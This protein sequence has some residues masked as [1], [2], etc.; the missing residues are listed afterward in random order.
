MFAPGGVVLQDASHYGQ[1]AS[2]AYRAAWTEHDRQTR[3]V[4][5]LADQYP[6]AEHAA[7]MADLAAASPWPPEP[8]AKGA[9]WVTRVGWNRTDVAPFTPPDDYVAGREH[10]IRV[11]VNHGRWIA[12]CPC[13]GAQLACRTDHRMFCVDCLNAHV[14][15]RWV[16]VIWPE[17][18][19]G[20]ED[21][22]AV[23][24]AVLQNWEPDE[25]VAVLRAENTLLSARGDLA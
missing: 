20:V 3:L 16:P 23:R 11:R 12:V 9:T 22:M 2:K 10:A 5:S 7:A 18:V 14:D 17:D 13:G 8:P 21:A 1:R 4:A 25:T 6:P 15:G 19:G 24:P